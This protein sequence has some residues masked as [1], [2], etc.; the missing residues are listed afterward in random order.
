MAG[1]S[2]SSPAARALDAVVNHC[3]L[4]HIELNYASYGADVRLAFPESR[5][6]SQIFPIAGKGEATVDGLSVTVDAD[7][8]V[9]V[10]GATGMTIT[11]NADYQRLIL[12][13]D[14]TSLADQL[15]SLTGIPLAA[16][17][18]VQPAQDASSPAARH[19]RANFLFLVNQMSAAA[20]PPP[21]LLAEFE[22][23][24]MTMFLHANRHNYS[25]L[26]AEDPAAVSGRAVRRAE[27]YIEAKWAG[28]INTADL[29][30]TSGVGVRSLVRAFL[31]QRGCSP[32]EFLARIRLRQAR[33]L[34]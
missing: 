25:H 4:Q 10:P 18:Q 3:C 8:S 5:F 34:Q 9:C 29:A 27:E 31:Q 33:P 17:L 32:R 30:A 6:V 11:T 1:R 26:L 13:I 21:V 7:H 14:A 23:A 2:W 19:L 22:Q 16:P 12:C 20:P 28:P 15:A 24:L